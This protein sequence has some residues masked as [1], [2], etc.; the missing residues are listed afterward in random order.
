MTGAVLVVDDSLTVRMDLL[1]ILEAGGLR[2]Q[3][4]A[5]VA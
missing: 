2:A 3:A 5:T 4:C 1:E